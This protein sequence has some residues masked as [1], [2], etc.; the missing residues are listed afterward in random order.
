MSFAVEMEGITKTFDDLKANDSIN[1]ELRTG[2]VHGLLGENGAGKTVLMSILYGIYKA[3]TGKIKV[4][5][6]EVQI[7]NSAD[8]I[9][10]GIGMVHQHFKLVPSLSVAE[11]IILGR[12]IRKNVLF[13]DTQ[14]AEDAVKA[15]SERYGLRV[16]PKATMRN[17]PVGLQQ[18]IE[19]L[20]ALFRGAEI[21]ILDEPTSVLTPQEVK[22]LFNAIEALK[23]QRKSVIFI[24]HKLKEVLTI[25]DR[26]TVLKKGKVV[27]T[28]RTNETTQ[29]KLAEMMVG[30]QILSAF[31]KKASKDGNVV[32][33]VE[34]L[35]IL[36]DRKVPAVQD[37]SFKVRKFE[38]LGLAG[39]E[40]N[41]QNELIEVLVGV[42]KL[43]SGK[44]YLK[45][46]LINSFSTH[47]RIESGLSQVPEDRQKRGLILDFSV[48]ENLILGRHYKSP[49]TTKRWRLDFK[50]ISD[51]SNQLI[52][53]YSIKTPSKDTLVRYLSGGTQQRVVVAREFST[54][55]SV[56]IASQ[57]TRGLDV[58]AT[59]YV[60]KKLVEMRDKGCAIFLVS[61]DLDE[62]MTLS[63]RIAVIYEGKIVAIKKRSETNELE[64]GLLMTGGKND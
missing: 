30:R 44:I 3:D 61:A 1:F 40:G 64:L 24:S 34:K 46:K 11:N 63:D 6:R 25:C 14:K 31:S 21:L 2:E 13:L 56:I 28:V 12:E 41:G 38:I 8:A 51:F 35:R 59:E 33:R 57:P 60:R 50:E 18:R 48:A 23:K 26:V 39:V 36:D 29:E 4:N 16:N 32:F 53:E 45:E 9:D 37:V 49:F 58:G 17:L 22:G 5:G 27:G 62:I 52:E 10:L 47:E 43:E 42:R 55:P 7:R 54:K 15:L 19:I 20:K